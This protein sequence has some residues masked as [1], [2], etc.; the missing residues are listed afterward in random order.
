MY[1]FV[2]R[3]NVQLIK[4]HLELFDLKIA[5]TE[6]LVEND[7]FLVCLSLAIKIDTYVSIAHSKTCLSF[8]C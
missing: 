1:A 7:V 8:N 3:I 4:V 2:D 6:I 5:I